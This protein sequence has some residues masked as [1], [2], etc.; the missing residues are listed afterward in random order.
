MYALIHYFMLVFILHALQ[1][2]TEIDKWEKLC[3]SSQHNKTKKKQF[4]KATGS[5]LVLE[6]IWL[7]K[8]LGI[9]PDDLTSIPGTY[10]ME[11]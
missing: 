4:R 1:C 7:V 8:V 5:K 2:S 11:G 6:M 3:F 9:N 10:M